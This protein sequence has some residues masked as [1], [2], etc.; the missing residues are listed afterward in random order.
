MAMFVAAQTGEGYTKHQSNAP[1]K[2]YYSIGNNAA[3]LPAGQHIPIKDVDS[4]PQKKGYYAI[5]QNNKK[6]QT[7][8]VLQSN[9]TKR[10]PQ[11]RKG[12]YSIGRNEEKL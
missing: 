6:Q 12:Y 3:R 10:T 8:F 7:T 5:A 11:I 9:T 2:G 4:E 1:M